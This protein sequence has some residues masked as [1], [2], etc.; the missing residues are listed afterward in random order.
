LHAFGGYTVETILREPPNIFFALGKLADRVLANDALENTL[1]AVN[2]ALSGDANRLR[3]CRG[4]IFV[5]PKTEHTAEQYQAAKKL[6]EEI[7]QGKRKLQVTDSL[8]V[9]R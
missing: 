4:E 8:K 3:S 1:P 2:A 6:A 7:S 5:M 9:K